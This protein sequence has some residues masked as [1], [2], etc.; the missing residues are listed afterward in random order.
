MSENSEESEGEEK[1]ENTSPTSLSDDQSRTVVIQKISKE[2]FDRNS[3]NAYILKKTPVQDDKAQS[4][5]G[6]ESPIIT[7]EIF[8]INGQDLEG[9]YEGLTINPSAKKSRNVIIRRVTKEEFE[10]NA[11][12]AYILKQT[13][14]LDDKSQPIASQLAHSVLNTPDKISN[15]YYGKKIKGK[16]PLGS[17]NRDGAILYAKRTKSAEKVKQK[18]PPLTK[19]DGP[20]TPEKDMRKIAKRR[21]NPSSKGKDQ[22]PFDVR[23]GPQGHVGDKTEPGRLCD[24]LLQ[25]VYQTLQTSQNVRSEFLRKNLCEKIEKMDEQRRIYQELT[26][27]DDQPLY[28]VYNYKGQGRICDVGE[29]ITDPLKICAKYKPKPYVNCI[30]STRKDESE[31]FGRKYYLRGGHIFDDDCCYFR[32]RQMFGKSRLGKFDTEITDEKSDD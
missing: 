28:C 3:E 31:C 19:H 23:R 7:G 4:P 5:D 29:K 25:Q 30:S 6:Q 18:T 20:H 27:K 26:E 8:S 24:P 10:Q 2:E 14:Y 1:F 22:K 17:I 9:D 16:N 32:H 11:G 12:N 15:I 13:P 21:E